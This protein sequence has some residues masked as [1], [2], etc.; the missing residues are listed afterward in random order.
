MPQ[1][2]GPDDCHEYYF[3]YIDRVPPAADVLQ[4]LAEQRRGFPDLL[5]R[6]PD[7][8]DYRYREDKWTVKEVVGHVIDTERTFLQRA[9]CAV[10][11]DPGELPDFDQDHYAAHARY[12]ERPMESILYEY[13]AVRG[14]SLAFFSELDAEEWAGRVRAAGRSFTARA[15]PYIVAGHQSHHEGELAA[16]YLAE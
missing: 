7:R 9:F 12:G 11:R 1:R 15:I 8:H 6:R 5:L 14:A 16:R 4:V 2:P 13:D 10:R 3:R